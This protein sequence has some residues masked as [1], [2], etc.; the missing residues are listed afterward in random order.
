[1]AT[2]NALS[3]ALFN[4]AA[5]G[6][7]AEMT[8]NA[9]G[10][11][12]AVGPI[13][14]KDVS[15]DALFVDHLLGN[16]GVTS[17]NAVYA[18]AKAAVAAL[19]TTKGR[20]GAAVDAIDFLKAQEGSTSAYATIAA[21][22][23]AKVNT[24]ATFTAANATER[25]ITKLVS[26]VTG[27]DTDV[28]AIAAAVAAAEA[29][30]AAELAAANAAAEA[31]ATAAADALAAAE[32]E[33]AAELAAANAAAEAAA[34]AAAAALAAAEAEAA[35]ELAAAEAAAADAAEAAAAEIATLEA[36]ITALENPAGG[37][38]ALT[39]AANTVIGVGRGDAITGTS[40][41]YTSDDVIVDAGANDG[42]TL[43][44]TATDDISA[45]PFVAG[46][47]TV[48]FNISSVDAGGDATFTVDAANITTSGITIAATRTGN[49]VT[50]AD[51][52]NVKSGITVTSALATIDLNTAA[53]ADVSVVG[54]R[55]AGTTFTQ[56]GTAD[57]LSITTTG[58]LTITNGTT[59]EEAITISAGG[60]VSITDAAANAAATDVD[61]TITAGGAITIIDIT[62]TGALTA[63]TTSGNITVGGTDLHTDEDVTLSTA[64]G[65]VTVTNAD[66][67]AG[68]LTVTAVGDNS[69][70]TTGADGTITVTS[71]DAATAAVL[72]ASAGIEIV[73]L[74]SATDV[75]LSAGAASTLGNIQSM[76]DLT[77]AS[78]NAA[79]TAV[80]FTAASTELDVLENLTATGSKSVTFVATGADLVTSATAAG[81][82][83]VAT[84]N[85]T[86]GTTTLKIATAASGAA[87]DL[88]DVAWDR[89]ELAV[90]NSTDALTL[91]TGANLLVSLSQ[92][93]LTLTTAA[94][95]GRSVNITL[96]HAT[97]G[98][99]VTL[100]DLTT[101]NF[102]TVNVALGDATADYVL[103]DIDVS[104]T[105]DLVVTGGGD[106]TVTDYTSLKSFNASAVT[107]AV[108]FSAVFNNKQITTGSGADSFTVN[109]GDTT[110]LNIDGGA[111]V[112][113]V[114]F[115]ASD[116][117]DAGTL[118]FS[119]IEK[120]DVSASGVVL[121]A[122][123]LTGKDYIIVA[124]ATIDTLAVNVV[125]T[126]GE[127]VNLSNISASLAAIT[128]TGNNG[129]DTITGSSTYGM[130]I[131]A[132]TGNDV[133]T[134][135]AGNDV[136]NGQGGSDT[137]VLG[138][139]TDNV[140]LDQISGK[141]TISGF[142]T[143]DDLSITITGV[144]TAENVVT[145]AGSA[146]ALTG[147]RTIFTINASTTSAI[148]TTGVETIASFTT[149]ADVAAWINEAGTLTTTTGVAAVVLNDGTN[150]YV[151]YVANDGTAAIAAA[152]VTL[153][154]VVEGHVLVAAN[155]S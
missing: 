77:V 148:A 62:D 25:D 125:S 141:D 14:E 6:Y 103:T 143:G 107:G 58:A 1:M 10:F 28:A 17:T 144:T 44:I 46:I 151:Y 50:T 69:S 92:T 129:L 122:S 119:N 139:G 19:V 89:I 118:N 34:T 42:D 130:T 45:V 3:V 72:T 59:A 123:Q 40:S 102:A 121:A 11:A 76:T 117:F 85:T 112:D 21:D 106:L 54:T 29:E 145:A 100:S 134:G 154:G 24:A 23:A 39:S 36:Q 147:D 97:T 91:A 57:T 37:S 116:D 155:V 109:D 43:T 53:N 152:E 108:T 18:Q 124:N 135:G 68:T 115:T 32:A 127:T 81:E 67:A 80:T 35:A 15:T 104:A 99:G 84:D 74:D 5:G 13:L 4:A 150:S 120:L 48:A 137:I 136:I 41:T 113:T 94:A 86:G 128:V 88:S 133:I 149:M 146:T 7:A 78:S 55:T 66:D 16:L 9:A 30:A 142:A 33:A 75:T 95:A 105:T 111:G 38:F 131:D 71:A 83:L 132:G 51:V 98:T 96:D 73:S 70:T 2:V 56:S 20:A 64:N 82:A 110:T 138:G 22:F 63:T 65:N 27:V 26:G 12:N 61:Y 93:N 140:I 49:V 87:L 114:V 31:A 52:D 60:A 153:V 126:T 101:T 90:D 79:G 8:A 47:E